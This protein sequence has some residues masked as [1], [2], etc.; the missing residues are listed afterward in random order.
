M[1]LYGT[2]HSAT[3]SSIAARSY[4]F[5]TFRH[6]ADLTYFRS[7]NSPAQHYGDIGVRFH[8]I[9]GVGTDNQFN[10]QEKNI[11]VGRRPAANRRNLGADDVNLHNEG[12]FDIEDGQRNRQV[13]V[14]P[15]WIKVGYGMCLTANCGD[16]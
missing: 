12:L 13:E 5:E 1:G 14:S 16:N 7:N 6:R 9:V 3:L 4:A 11:Y 8:G 15:I 10:S 2:I